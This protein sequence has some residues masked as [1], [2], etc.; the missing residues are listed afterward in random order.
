MR[1]LSLTA[2]PAQDWADLRRA[3]LD[4]LKENATLLQRFSALEA[5]GTSGVPPAADAVADGSSTASELVLR[6]SCAAVCQEKHSSRTS[7]VR[8]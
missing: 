8:R 7:S 5:S 6:A 1:V 3:A 2:N 4:R